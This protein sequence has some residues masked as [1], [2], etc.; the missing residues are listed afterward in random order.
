MRTMD[1]KGLGTIVTLLGLLLLVAVTAAACG[2]GDGGTDTSGGDAGTL[3]GEI[4]IDG[5]S[6]VYPI[7]EAV[8]DE[9]Q[10]ENG[11]VR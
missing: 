4:R 8:A 1:R 11:D 5:S 9:F 10:R 6:T 3:A 7:S 2:G